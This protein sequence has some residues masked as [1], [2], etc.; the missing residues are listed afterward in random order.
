MDKEIELKLG[1]QDEETMQALLSDEVILGDKASTIHMKATYYDTED[2]LL[3]KN[4][5][6]LRL[7][8]EDE[9]IVAT[10]KYGGEVVDGLH[11]R[12][13]INRPKEDFSLSIAD[14]PQERPM[15]EKILGNQEW[16]PLI[17]TDIIRHVRRI[18]YMDSVLEC[19]LDEGLVRANDQSVNIREL[20]VELIEGSVEALEAF[21]KEELGD[22]RL[23]PEDMSKL[24]RGLE[25]V[26]R[27]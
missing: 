22:Y 18:K 11:T 1:I 21:T 17:V 20:E 14:F 24:A 2:L 23:V 10:L 9:A 7:R 19:A 16:R 27:K 5:I 12:V 25:L 26:R 13:E 8:W 3:A 15:L 6:G 4:R